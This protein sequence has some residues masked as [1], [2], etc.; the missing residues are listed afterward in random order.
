MFVKS[1]KRYMQ[2][3][4]I[5]VKA[6]DMT[7]KPFGVNVNYITQPALC[8]EGDHEREKAVTIVEP[9][10]S[11]SAMYNVDYLRKII[12]NLAPGTV[13]KLT[14]GDDYPL[15]IEGLIDAET[16]VTAYLAPYIEPE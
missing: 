2:L 6:K 15:K 9:S 11:C 8:F 10:E 7:P 1:V 5:G 4:N 13:V 14:I 3:M 16:H 12:D